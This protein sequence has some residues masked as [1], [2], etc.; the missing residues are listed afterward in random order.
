[1]QYS[2]ILQLILAVLMM[3]CGINGELFDFFPNSLLNFITA[4]CILYKDLG[5]LKPKKKI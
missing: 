2:Q 5:P 1:M 4:V 3:Y